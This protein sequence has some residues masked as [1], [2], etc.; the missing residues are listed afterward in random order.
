MNK[1]AVSNKF[2][3]GKEHTL[4][5]TQTNQQGDMMFNAWRRK[6]YHADVIFKSQPK[7]VRAVRRLWADHFLPGYSLW[8]GDW[9]NHLD[10]YDTVIVH[11][12]VRTRTVPQYIH[13]LKPEMRVIYWYWNPVNANSLPE[14]TG[15]NKIECWS[16]NPSDCRKYNMH[17]N[18]QYY[19]DAEELPHE[20]IAYDVYYVGHDKG[21]KSKL[22]SFAKCADTSK[23][24]F[25]MDLVKE[26]EKN[27]PY[28]EVQK[29]ISR[30]KA[31]L[32][33][34]Q[35]GQDGC[36]LRALEALFFEKKLITDN[37]KIKEEA[38]YTPENI[39]ILGEDDIQNLKEFIDAPYRPMPGMKARYTMDAWF[40]NF[41]GNGKVV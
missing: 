36:T 9:K 4:L 17:R 24:K 22:E 33:I 18:I 34:L 3:Q 11:A 35:S 14:L 7:L 40:A 8:Y 2:H 15:D 32:E 6:G 27:I 16:F 28:E 1:T 38:F 26:R 37:S 5:L 31:I 25:K 12:D 41:F 19:R 10:Q 30:A 29:R 21:R 23:I 20:A 13:R 39:F